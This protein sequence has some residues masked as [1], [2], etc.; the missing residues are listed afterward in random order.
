[1]RPRE[2]EILNV[3]N[4]ISRIMDSH[5]IAEITQTGTSRVVGAIYDIESGKVEFFE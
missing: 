3:E 5:I 4:S 2:A 1:M